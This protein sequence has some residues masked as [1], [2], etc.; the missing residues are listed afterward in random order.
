MNDNHKDLIRELFNYFTEISDRSDNEAKVLIDCCRY[1]LNELK[2]TIRDLIDKIK[3]LQAVILN[4][5]EDYDQDIEDL[6]A[7]IKSLEFRKIDLEGRLE[8]YKY[9]SMPEIMS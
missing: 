2:F 7:K 5:E 6:N 3:E 4:L 1:N 9:K 8:S